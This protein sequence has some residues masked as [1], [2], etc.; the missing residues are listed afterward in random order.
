MTLAKNHSDAFELVKVMYK[1]LL[2]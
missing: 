2:V 1:T